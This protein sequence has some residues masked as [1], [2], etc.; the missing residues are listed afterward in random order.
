MGSK[1]ISEKILLSS[2]LTVFAI[3]MAL[4][5]FKMS[6]VLSMNEKKEKKEA[7]YY[8]RIAKNILKNVE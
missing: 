7:K 5:W 2:G 4:F 6:W 1:L 8:E 3:F